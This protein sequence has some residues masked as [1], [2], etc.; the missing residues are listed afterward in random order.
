M[1]NV[2]FEVLK[3]EGKKWL[4]KRRLGTYGFIHGARTFIIGI[5]TKPSKYDHEHFGFLFEKI[6][7]FATSLDLGT[8]WLGGTFRRSEFKSQLKLSANERIP[9]I[10]PIGIPNKQNIRS[11]LIKNFARSQKRKL[12]RDLFFEGRF[13]RSLSKEKVDKLYKPLEMVRLAP[14]ASNSQPWRIIKDQNE[15]I[16]HFFSKRKRSKSLRVFRFPDF[17]RIDM[18]IA[19]YHFHASVIQDGLIGKWYVLKPDIHIPEPLE[20]LISWKQEDK[21]TN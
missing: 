3:L 21:I 14:S 11:T 9:A 13:S 5:I 12:W 8:C 4:E 19:V 7:L 20:Y 6:I 18:G 1:G 2:R 10:T 16:Y 15:H 17:P